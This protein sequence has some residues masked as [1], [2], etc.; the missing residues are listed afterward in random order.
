MP[1]FWLRCRNS[2]L[3]CM[4]PMTKEAVFM[5][6]PNLATTHSPSR[7][8]CADDYT[9]YGIHQYTVIIQYTVYLYVVSVLSGDWHCFST[10]R[11]SLVGGVQSASDAAVAEARKIAAA[12]MAQDNIWTLIK[13]L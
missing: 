7:Q 1:G 6:E 5:C 8:M 2:Q 3:R 12:M 10:M 9:Q 4:P 11:F 13:C